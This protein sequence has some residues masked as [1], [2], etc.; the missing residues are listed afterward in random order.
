MAAMMNTAGTGRGAGL[1]SILAGNQ[2]TFEEIPEGWMRLPANYYGDEGRDQATFNY[3]MN[4]V[5]G[6][7]ISADEWAVDPARWGEK[8]K[9]DALGKN[10]KMAMLS[11]M[12]MGGGALLSGAGGF[13]ALGAETIAGAPAGAEALAGVTQLGEG[14]G[15]V[16][17][18]TGWAGGTIGGAAG[19]PI[20]LT[21][22]AAVGGPAADIMSMLSAGG[23]G[24]G[25][26]NF[27]F[28]RLG[29]FE[30]GEVTPDFS[31]P[32]GPSNFGGEGGLLDTVSAAAPDFSQF[33]TN[34]LA[35][36]ATPDFMPT[37]EAGGPLAQSAT[38]LESPLD[39]LKRMYKQIKPYSGALDV[40]KG[41]YGMSQGNKVG[42]LAKPGQ[43]AGQQL[44]ELLAD[45]SRITSLPGYQELLK[46]RTT[47]LRRQMAAA[48]YNMSGNEM[49]AIANLGGAQYMEFRNQ[50]M[51]RLQSLMQTAQNPVIA[52]G[53]ARANS[54]NSIIYGVGRLIG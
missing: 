9:G 10:A 5:G 16:A 21:P 30:G 19:G 28:S 13:G 43:M 18:G 8:T 15:S 1:Q 49:D 22:A 37:T 38:G 27:D 52:A 42:Q 36:E 48:G 46:Q 31:G 29:N 40:L 45:P 53:N 14:V 24:A 20:T 51:A 25:A 41:L 23:A 6:K 7:Q 47:G 50:E 34:G 44:Q 35:P 4:E 11:A 33:S 54:L 3:N 32:E 17:G 2:P 26:G 12:I 39:Q